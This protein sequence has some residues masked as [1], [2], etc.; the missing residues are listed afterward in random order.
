MD[1]NIRQQAMQ[2]VAQAETPLR[3][4]LHTKQ[5][6]VYDWA[7]SVE[8]QVG[9]RYTGRRRDEYHC[10]LMEAAREVRE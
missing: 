2:D 9:I 6:D 8:Y 1:D 4:F 5:G 7:L 10:A 3:K